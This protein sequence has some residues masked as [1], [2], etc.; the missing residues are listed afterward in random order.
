MPSQLAE[1]TQRITV[2]VKTADLKVLRHTLLERGLTLSEWVRR[3]MAAEVKR[4]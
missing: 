3:K 2:T 4:K 1:G